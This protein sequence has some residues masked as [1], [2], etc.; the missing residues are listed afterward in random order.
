VG[1]PWSRMVAARRAVPRL[2]AL[3][4]RRAG[5]RDA[6]KSGGA[7]NLYARSASPLPCLRLYAEEVSPCRAPHSPALRRPISRCNRA[8]AG[9]RSAGAA[10]LGSW[11]GQVGAW[12][13]ARA[14]PS[15]RPDGLLGVGGPSVRNRTVAYCTQCH[16]WSGAG[17]FRWPTPRAIPLGHVYRTQ[18]HPPR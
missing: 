5:A 11:G 7:T 12:H 9:R 13:A 10:G 4:A 16:G 2:R 8:C 14:H 15:G 17:R 6:P 18:C 1:I 3:R